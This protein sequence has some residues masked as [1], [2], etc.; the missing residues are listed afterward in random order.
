MYISTAIS[1]IEWPIAIT[2]IV[3]GL[4]QMMRPGEWLKFMPEWMKRTSPF[5]LE[6]DMRLHA[7]GNIVFGL[8]LAFGF[9]HLL[10]AVWIAFVWWLSIVPFAWKV[11]WAL[12][13]RDLCISLALAALIFLM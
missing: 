7:I 3:F 1:L 6:T 13:M 9:G 12:G 4:H 11:D 2:M 5:K 8:F 10:V